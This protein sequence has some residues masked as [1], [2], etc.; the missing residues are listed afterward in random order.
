MSLAA[1]NQVSTLHVAVRSEQLCDSAT[2]DK[3]DT[4]HSFII[5]NHYFKSNS[6]GPYICWSTGAA[7]VGFELW[8]HQDKNTTDLLTRFQSQSWNLHTSL[9]TS[10]SHNVIFF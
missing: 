5:I 4:S 8:K 2:E 10:S 7:P 6:N 9:N 1:F 3:I